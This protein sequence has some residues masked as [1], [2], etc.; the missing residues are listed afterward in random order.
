MLRRVSRSVAEVMERMRSDE[1][2]GATALAWDSTRLVLDISYFM[3]MLFLIERISFF[4][5]S[6]IFL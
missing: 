6:I 1:A 5:L 3:E 2:V 4:A